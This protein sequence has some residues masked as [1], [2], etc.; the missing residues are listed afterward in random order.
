MIEGSWLGPDKVAHAFFAPVVTLV[1]ARLWPA[2][3]LRAWIASLMVGLVW[4]ASNAWFVIEGEPGISVL[5]GIAFAVGW[6][7]VGILLY[8]RPLHGEGSG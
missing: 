3:R 8:L 5:D 1:L 7:G 6:I 4:E 2:W